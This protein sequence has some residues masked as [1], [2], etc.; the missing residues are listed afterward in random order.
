LRLAGALGRFWWIA[1]HFGE[2]SRWLA[3]ALAGGPAGPEVRMKALH[4]AG[5][6]AHL[7]RNSPAA[8][9]L[10]ESSLAIA[11]ERADDWWRAWVVH[12]LGRVAYFEDDAP[13]A[14]EL[15]QR[16]LTIAEPL[17]DA[18]LI[19]DLTAGLTAYIGATTRRQ[20][21]TTALCGRTARAARLEG[22]LI[23]L[24]L[25][26]MAAI[27]LGQTTEA[28]ALTREALTSRGNSTPPGSSRRAPIFANL[29][30]DPNAL[31]D[32]AALSPP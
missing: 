9:T 17:G 5:W 18:W 30:A 19:M 13:R 7:Q 10:L 26:A 1:G 3:R 12:A 29:A 32:W 24:L 31:R 22:L 4:D 27:P 25:K 28:L 21:R 11:E 20:T 16:S 15:A 6:L 2:C 8:R 23:V 14:A